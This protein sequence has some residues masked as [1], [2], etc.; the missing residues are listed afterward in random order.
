MFTVTGLLSLA[1]PVKVGAVVLDGD[2]GLFNVTAG[3]AVSTV[4]VAAE[5]VPGGL[6]SEL[7]CV[8]VAVYCPLAKVGLALPEV[9]A[10][11]VPGAV[12]VETTA[13]VAVGPA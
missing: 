1:E 13:P 2:G 7:V 5:L 3:A 8:A 10:P 12:A 11:P 6:P 9:Q 4:N